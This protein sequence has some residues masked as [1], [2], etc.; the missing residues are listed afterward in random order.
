MHAQGAV[1][2][3]Q[4]NQTAKIGLKRRC[5]YICLRPVPWDEARMSDRLH[6]NLP[7]P[8]RA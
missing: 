3:I 7:L 4:P 8:D 6:H 5:V 1:R 2:D